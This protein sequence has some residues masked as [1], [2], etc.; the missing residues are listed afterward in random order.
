MAWIL[1]TIYAILAFFIFDS[2]IIHETEHNYLREV[3]KPVEV[4]KRYFQT[5]DNPIIQVVEKLVYRQ[6][7][8]EVEKKIYVDRPRKKLN[9]PRYNFVGS[10]ETKR[11]H[12]RNC[13][14]GKLIKKKYKISNNSKEFFK[15]RGFKGCKMCIK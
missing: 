8:V 6:V 3:E 13:R 14:L 15:H 5:I 11:F 12:S 9:I 7:P 10:S 2:R 1:T 4:V